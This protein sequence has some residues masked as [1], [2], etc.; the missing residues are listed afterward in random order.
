VDSVR[1]HFTVLH[2]TA[3]LLRPELARPQQSTLNPAQCRR[4]KKMLES[5]CDSRKT[6][7]NRLRLHE[8]TAKSAARTFLEHRGTRRTVMPADP[9]ATCAKDFR[10]D[11]AASRRPRS[12]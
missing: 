10:P 9:R 12:T 7:L 4:N 6:H 2:A 3:A 5:C 8:K 1:R 11:T